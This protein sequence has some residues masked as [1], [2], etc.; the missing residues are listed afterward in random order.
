MRHLWKAVALVSDLLLTVLFWFASPEDFRDALAALVSLEPIELV[1]AVQILF[2]SLIVAWVIF[3]ER[4][5][6]PTIAGRYRLRRLSPLVGELL[7]FKEMRLA[8]Q[9][10]PEL[11]EHFTAGQLS[12]KLDDLRVPHPDLTIKKHSDWSRRDV[13]RFF[14]MLA[15]LTG[16]RNLCAEGNL[17]KARTFY[18]D[19]LESA[20]SSRL[21][22]SLPVR[23][24]L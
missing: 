8:D 6:L 22:R 24:D 20:A 1:I 18:T 3:D 21:D 2:L 23:R 13:D 10:V 14:L 4:E 7:Q 11:S 16:L 19:A 5:N 15:F 12:K 9:T 17:K